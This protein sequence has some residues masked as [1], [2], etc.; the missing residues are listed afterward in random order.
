MDHGGRD[1]ELR[2]ER[3]QEEAKGRGVAGVRERN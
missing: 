2:W 3:M 1:E